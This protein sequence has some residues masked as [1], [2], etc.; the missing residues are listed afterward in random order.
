MTTPIGLSQAADLLDQSLS[1]KLAGISDRRDRAGFVAQGAFP[2]GY[3]SGPTGKIAVDGAVD[4]TNVGTTP[5]APGTKARVHTPPDVSLVD[6]DVGTDRDA[7]F[8]SH[9]DYMDVLNAISAAGEVTGEAYNYA[10]LRAKRLGYL[11]RTVL[12]RNHK[13][14]N[15]IVGDSS[16]WNSSSGDLDNPAS[17][18]ATD[19][20]AVFRNAFRRTKGDTVLCPLDVYDALLDAP[21]LKKKLHGN[22]ESDK[23]LTHEMLVDY[24][25]SVAL[26]P[27]GRRVNLVIDRA[28]YNPKASDYILSD[29]LLVFRGA[30]SSSGTISAPAAD[31]SGIEREEAAAGLFCRKPHDPLRAGAGRSG[32]GLAALPSATNAGSGDPLNGLTDAQRAKLFGITLVVND[33]QYRDEDQVQYILRSS[34]GMTIWDADGGELIGAVAGRS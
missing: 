19:M 22:G 6:V 32:I 24:L 3:T 12:V 8:E 10:T 14:L 33:T 25:S 13:R 26:L 18:A 16:N 2:A 4:M 7:F 34:Y 27:G 31:L 15:A 23:L 30:S 5:S 9:T 28:T 17:N 29:W 1:V 11:H 20:H 21:S